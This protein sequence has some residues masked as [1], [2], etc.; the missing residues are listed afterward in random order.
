MRSNCEQRAAGHRSGQ[1]RQGQ[2]SDFLTPREIDRLIVSTG[3]GRVP[4]P[5]TEQDASIVVEW[6]RRVRIDHA[7]LGMVLD[8]RMVPAGMKDGR[9]SFKWAA[10]LPWCWAAVL[11][12]KPQDVDKMHAS[13]AEGR[14]T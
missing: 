13:R 1:P 9:L 4:Q 10:L 14:R 12:A 5:M 2:E 11:R 7:M 8:G 3:A 6:A